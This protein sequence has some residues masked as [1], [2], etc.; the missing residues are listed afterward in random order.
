MTSD[1]V[2]GI[3]ITEMCANGLRETDEYNTKQLGVH[4]VTS[5]D[6]ATICTNNYNT[7]VGIDTGH[8]DTTIQ[9]MLIPV[10]NDKDV[11]VIE[12]RK[13]IQ[14][15]RKTMDPPRVNKIVHQHQLKLI[16]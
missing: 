16:H 3:D 1:G 6:A 14:I 13:N 8:K 9:S 7:A 4:M 15:W 2:P 11:N 5:F 10:V 12:H